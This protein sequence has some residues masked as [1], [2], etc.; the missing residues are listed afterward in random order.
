MAFKKKI[1]TAS[2]DIIN[3]GFD[4]EFTVGTNFLI[5]DVPYKVVE[6][7]ESDNTQM[8]RIS[9]VNNE[10]DCEV[11][12]LASLKADLHFGTIKRS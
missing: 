8:R 10:G 11:L 7:F 1:K 5:N 6:E 12:T 2:M 3:S 9:K 4:S